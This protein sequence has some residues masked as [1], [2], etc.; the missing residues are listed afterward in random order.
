MNIQRMGLKMEFICGNM[1]TLQNNEAIMG[2]FN[3]MTNMLGHANNPNFE[4]MGN[5]LQNFEKTMDD[6]LINGK[7]MEEMMNS[8]N[9]VADNTAEDMLGVLKGE[10]AMD[11]ANQV[12]EAA[13]IKQQEIAFQDDLKKL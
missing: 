10:L 11:T 6:M 8:S 13:T 12:S 1:K 2:S 5:N 3:Q 9:G 7:M 4:V